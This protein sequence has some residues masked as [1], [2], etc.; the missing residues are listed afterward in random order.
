M[1]TC[2]WFFNGTKYVASPDFPHNCPEGHDCA[3]PLVPDPPP[4]YGHEVDDTCA[5]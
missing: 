5:L 1:G 4:E 2:R 3:E